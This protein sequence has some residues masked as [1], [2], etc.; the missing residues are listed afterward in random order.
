VKGTCWAR[1]LSGKEEGTLGSRR[2]ERS[3]SP[4]SIGSFKVEL[5]FVSSKRRVRRGNK[6]GVWTKGMSEGG[7]DC[8]QGLEFGTLPH[9]QRGSCWKERIGGD[10]NRGGGEGAAEKRASSGQSF[11][12]TSEGGGL[13]CPRKSR[14]E[15]RPTC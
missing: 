4:R 13:N 12:I 8:A 7:H 11:C 1:F 10:P 3:V 14:E 9:G 5:D 6:K 15:C 2:R